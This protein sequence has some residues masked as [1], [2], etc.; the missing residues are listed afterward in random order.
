[1]SVDKLVDSRESTVES[2]QSSI[3]SGLSTV[4]SRLSTLDHAARVVI[5]HVRP[6]VDG[7]RF[8]IKR[9]TGERVEVR[10]DIFADGHDVIAV[11]LRDRHV[12]SEVGWRET[13]M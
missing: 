9:T 13:P 4:D 1:M 11:V 8:P 12:G 3:D 6:S 2:R 5:E 10:A 7:G